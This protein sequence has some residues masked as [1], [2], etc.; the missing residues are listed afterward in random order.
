[1]FS[2]KVEEPM[3]S[4]SRVCRSSERASDV[5]LS[6]QQLRHRYHPLFVYQLPGDTPDPQ[7]HDLGLTEVAHRET[8]C[9]P[10]SSSPSAHT[11]SNPHPPRGR[12][13]QKRT[14]CLSWIRG[15]AQRCGRVCGTRQ[16]QALARKAQRLPAPRCHSA[17]PLGFCCYCCYR[18]LHPAIR[19][20]TRGI[21]TSRGVTYGCSSWMRGLLSWNVCSIFED[22]TFP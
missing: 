9:C 17:T 22:V 2:E 5:L 8:R 18:D 11:N 6:H 16:R 4:S 14:P 7:V 3:N 19:L 12:L 21:K 10:S 1:M 20:M 15:S 13:S